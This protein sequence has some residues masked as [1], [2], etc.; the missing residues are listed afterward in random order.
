MKK[1][2]TRDNAERDYEK[3][4]KDP[5]TS[6]ARGARMKALEREPKVSVSSALVSRQSKSAA[7]KRET[8]PL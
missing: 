6:E 1:E 8:D 4:Q 5:Q 7:R 3:G 2:A